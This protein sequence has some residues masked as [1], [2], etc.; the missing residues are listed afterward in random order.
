VTALSALLI[1]FIEPTSRAAAAR[2]LAYRLRCERLFVLLRQPDTPHL[3]S[4]AAMPWA[5]ELP[6]S[7]LSTVSQAAP[8]ALLVSET[9]VVAGLADDAVLLVT[10][11]CLRPRR[12]AAV[13]PAL[14]LAV[15]VIRCR[16]AADASAR[17]CSELRDELERVREISQRASTAKDEFLATLS[18]ELR[19]PLNAMLGWTQLLR[20]SLDD[21]VVREHAITVIERSARIQAQI[22]SDLLD[23]SRAITGQLPV[24]LEP[25]DLVDIVGRSLDAVRPSARA[26]RVTIDVDLA[27]IAGVVRGDSVRLRQVVWNLLSNALKFTPSGGHITVRL[28][29]T[30]TDVAFE[31][32]DTGIG[33]APDLIPYVFDR[34]KQGDSSVTRRYGGL[35]L[36]LAIVRHLV[37][38]HGGSVAVTSGG[39]DHGATFTVCLPLQPADDPANGGPREPPLTHP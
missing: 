9:T 33:I 26:R 4:L 30:R 18:H 5:D 13:V 3:A 7:M 31:V 8:G 1:G 29:Q 15:A 38:L 27:P 14:T 21:S 22:V 28:H 39:T 6:A 34:F 2:E 37:E 24:V 20:M 36:G 11:C 12:I 17:H 10:G 19:T 25:V 16:Q 32:S 35:G 23:V